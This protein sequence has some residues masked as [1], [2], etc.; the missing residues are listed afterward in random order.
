MPHRGRLNVLANVVRKPGQAIFNEFIGTPNNSTAGG[1]DVKYHL[2]ANYERPVPNGKRVS[3][4]LVAN[5]SH[6]EA[7][8]G[9]VLGKTRGLQVFEKDPTSAMAVLLSV[10]SHSHRLAD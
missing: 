7:A 2:G 6:L 1:G 8:N 3:L 9:P 10:S 5:P 4:S